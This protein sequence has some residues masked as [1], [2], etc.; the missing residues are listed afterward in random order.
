M[1]TNSGSG[2]TPY[3]LERLRR[4]GVIGE[5]GLKRNGLPPT[6]DDLRSSLAA[7]N[8]QLDAENAL[9]AYANSD[10]ARRHQSLMRAAE[11]LSRP[12]GRSGVIM[13]AQ[14]KKIGSPVG[15]PSSSS[16]E[17]VDATAWADLQARAYYGR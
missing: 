8:A 4:E 3:A 10:E 5:N 11:G 14:P 1:F 12:S 7:E 2:M 15:A 13:G 16:G 9:K 17:A 6:D